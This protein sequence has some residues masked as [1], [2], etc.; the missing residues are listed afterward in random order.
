[1]AEKEKCEHI[2]GKE[3]RRAARASRFSPFGGTDAPVSKRKDGA[4]RDLAG[5]PAKKSRV[6]HYGPST[7]TVPGFGTARQLLRSVPDADEDWSEE[8]EEEDDELTL[9]SEVDVE[10]GIID[11][12]DDDDDD[13]DDDGLEDDDYDELA[14]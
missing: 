14:D 13:Y 11:D 8:E 1:M 10:E 4:G 5:P 3:T 12:E 7:T 9:E 6:V 2:E